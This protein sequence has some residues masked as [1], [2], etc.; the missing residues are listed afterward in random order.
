MTDSPKGP[1]GPPKTSIFDVT[2]PGSPVPEAVEAPIAEGSSQSLPLRPK[3]SIFE[4]TLPGVPE[5]VSMPAAI[6]ESD[7]LDEGTAAEWNPKWGNPSVGAVQAPAPS[8]R[9]EWWPYV[10]GGA[11]LLLAVGAWWT[12]RAA[13]PQPPKVLADKLPATPV[14]ISPTMKAYH[15]RAEAGDVNAM[16]LLG[17]SYGYGLGV[18]A[19]QAKGILWLRRAAKAGNHVAMEE[20]HALGGSLE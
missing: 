11:V 17:L 13:R 1:L 16:R 20:L 10:V 18:P 12:F 19:D 4:Q 8:S 6:V 2:L 15:D 3:T 5:P 14:D 7:A 9:M